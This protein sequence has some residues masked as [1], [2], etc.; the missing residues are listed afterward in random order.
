MAA[1][2]S[3]KKEIERLREQINIANIKYYRDDNP[4]ISDAEYDELMRRLKELEKK[5]PELMTPDSPTQ[6][7]GAAPLE[8]FEKSTHLM[9]MMSLD[10]ATGADEIR[11]FDQR[12]K[13]ML[14]IKQELEYVAEPKV[15]GLAMNLVYENGLLV[16]GATRG[17]GIEG[18]DVTQNLKTIK[19][20]PLRMLA[21]KPPELIE[22][23][24]EVY[25]K[26]DEFNQLNKGRAKTG[27]PLFANPRNAA[28]GSVRQLDS[29]ITASRRLHFWAYQAGELRGADFATQWD[30]LGRIREWGF[31]V[32]KRIKLCQGIDEVIKVWEDLWKARDTVEY[33]IDG[34]VIKINRLDLWRR[35]GETARAPRWALAAKF[36]ARQETSVVKDIMVGVGRT[37]AL[38]PVAVLEPVEI[39]GVV[40]KRATLHNEDEVKR[41]DIRI[42]DT[43]IVQRAGD[44]IPEVV[45]F[46]PEKRP[47]STR[48][49]K[50]PDKCPVCGSKVVREPDEAIHRCV[51]INCPAQ[52]KERIIHF[53][54]RDAMDIE[55]LGEKLVEKFF[56]KGLLKSIADIYRLKKSEIAAL[57]GLGDKSAQNLID[58]IEASKK[59]SL[60]RF[61]N[62]LGIRHVGE[63]T[64]E[65]LADSFGSIESLQKAS[66]EEL[67][68]NEG[69]GPEVAAAIKGFFDT[70]ENEKL[71]KELLE[72]GISFEKRK[73][74]VVET[75]LTGK[76]VV[77][78]GG[79][80]SLTRDE[81]KILIQKGGGRVGSSVSKKT[82]LVIVGAE[83]G[84]KLDKAKE[85]GIK[86]INEKEFVAM[87]KN[88]G[89]L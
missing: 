89:L 72:L 46:I 50:M 58:A 85:L 6:R 4:E 45:K 68:S 15:D 56:E 74:V 40:V 34:L 61:L 88:A 59:T 20:I 35:L 67:M 44:V 82:D 13:R 37:G 55:G 36:E 62:A 75:P 79:L 87:L 64:A 14:G 17:D 84:T 53:A 18:E 81:A 63:S 16:K 38:T 3:V 21:K 80:D 60:A 54:S 47:K 49:F 28:A 43:V 7:V 22:V 39:G 78:T 19:E 33:E 69:I 25:M 26:L 30:F 77:L 29:N 83:A 76:T 8:K 2:E 86:S 71:I 52:A 10:N 51:N 23:R 24:G 27:E 5:Y 12:V 42:G 73:K 32:Q 65:L 11:D 70:K 1:P 48:P 31:P 57:E 66:L 41:K 9:P